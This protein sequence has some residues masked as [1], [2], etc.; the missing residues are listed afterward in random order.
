MIKWSSFLFQILW[1]R[2]ERFNLIEV[3]EFIEFLLPTA[4]YQGLLRH[5]RVS[6]ETLVIEYHIQV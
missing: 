3:K 4:I 6:D 5:S 1:H 2:L